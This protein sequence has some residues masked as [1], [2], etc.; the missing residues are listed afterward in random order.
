ME[1]I[2]FLVAA[3]FAEIVAV[4]AGFGAATVL[5][6]VVAF[7]YDIG[8][9]VLLVAIFHIF[10]EGFP[11]ILFRKHVHW[12]VAAFF[13]APALAATVL[14]ARL[15]AVL[16][17]E[18]IREVLGWFIIAWALVSF[19]DSRFQLP[20]HAPM[21]FGGG[22]ASGFIAGLIGTGGAIRSMAL[23]SFGLVR[24]TYLGTSAVISVAVD[25]TRIPL[26]LA[27]GIRVESPLLVAGLAAIALAGALIGRKIVFK[28]PKPVFRKVVVAAL[29]LAGLGFILE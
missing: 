24:E 2:Y 23:T 22:I 1:T 18:T 3:F 19:F 8:Q 21:L 13:G 14:G 6:T 4:M 16:P 11:A 20:A 25:I 28:I 10:A 12:R 26:Y 29:F 27:S 15:I 7:F 5:T 9:A 17:S